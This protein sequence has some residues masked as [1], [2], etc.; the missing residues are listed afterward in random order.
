MNSINQGK[1]IRPAGRARMAREGYF[2]AYD[3]YSPT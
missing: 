3:I 2:V 1:G